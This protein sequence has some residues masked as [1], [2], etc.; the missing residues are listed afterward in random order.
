MGKPLKIGA[1]RGNSTAAEAAEVIEKELEH[2]EATAYRFSVAPMMDW[3]G[4]PE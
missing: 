3:A 4:S 2:A 1:N